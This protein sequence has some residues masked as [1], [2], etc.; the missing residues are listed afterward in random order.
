[1]EARER[2]RL[3]EETREE[4][5]VISY[6]EWENTNNEKWR[7]DMSVTSSCCHG[8]CDHHDLWFEPKTINYRQITGWPHLNQCFKTLEIIDIGG[9]NVFGEFVY[10]SS[11]FTPPSSSPSASGSRL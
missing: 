7:R 10:P 8:V 5:A 3:G 6:E 1:M 4:K 11:S 2:S 9:S